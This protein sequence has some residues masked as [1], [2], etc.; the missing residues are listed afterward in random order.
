MYSFGIQDGAGGFASSGK[1]GLG[2]G[3][4][5]AS[6]SSSGGFEATEILPFDGR[7]FGFGGGAIIINLKNNSLLI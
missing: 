7:G 5:D 1:G 4:P 3:L 2:G 6:F